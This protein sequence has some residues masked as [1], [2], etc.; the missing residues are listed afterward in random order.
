MVHGLYSEYPS[1]IARPLRAALD[2]SKTP[3]ALDL[4]QHGAGFS[5]A[6]FLHLTVEPAAAAVYGFTAA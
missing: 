4:D 3:A 5:P 2:R 6:Q 1:A